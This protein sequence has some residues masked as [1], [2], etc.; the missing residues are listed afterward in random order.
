[1]M[2]SV[3]LNENLDWKAAQHAFSEKGWV[4]ID[5]VLQP[6]FSEDIWRSLALDLQWDLVYTGDAM[7]AITMPGDEMLYLTMEQR[8]SLAA[9]MLRRAQTQYAFYY[10]KK[11]LLD[12]ENQVL[13]EFYQVIGSEK[14]FGFVRYVTGALNASRSSAIATCYQPSCFH[15]QNNAEVPGERRMVGQIFGFSRHWQPHWGGLLHLMDDG[16]NIRDVVPP[17][18]NT[19]VLYRV[20]TIHFISQ[21]ATYAPE[22]SYSIEGWLSAQA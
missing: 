5:Q 2:E 16:G 3:M 6:E 18:F 15:K 21:M 14:Y 20:P 19:L 9:E 7:E 10:Y 4:K 17:D 12:T 8:S 22:H 1:M 11:D 13:K